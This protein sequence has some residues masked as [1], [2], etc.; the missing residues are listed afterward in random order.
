[1]AVYKQPKS[2]YWCYKFTWN[3]ELIRESTKQTNKRVAEQMEAAHRT[4]LA[5]GEVGI[6]ERKPVP[7]L[8][9][10]AENDFLPFVR[11][12]FAAKPK[13]MAY[14]K[15]GV[16]RLLAFERIAGERL[17]VITSDKVAEFITKRQEAKGKRGSPLRVS[18]L[19]REL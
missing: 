7:S 5:K 12:T 4:A 17:D 6:R 16:N 1:M 19:N 2:K 18:S 14:Y 3:G 10:F 9:D 13:T 8:K 15:N 11:S